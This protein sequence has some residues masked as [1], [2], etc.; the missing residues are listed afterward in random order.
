M[1]KIVI[2][3]VIL[4]T[5]FLTWCDKSHNFMDVENPNAKEDLINLIWTWNILKINSDNIVPDSLSW[6]RDTTKWYVNK[7]YDDTIWEYVDKAKEW[8]WWAKETVKWYYN[9]WV[10][11][12][13]RMISDKVN[14]TISWELNKFKIK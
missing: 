10:D 8:L 2:L 13:N 14:S 9:E 6:T 1:K 5:A 11:E 7:Y 12:L 3:W 4:F